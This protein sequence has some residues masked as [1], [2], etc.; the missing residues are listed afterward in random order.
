MARVRC[1]LRVDI[2]YD[3]SLQKI[4]TATIQLPDEDSYKQL[5]G[6]EL[7]TRDWLTILDWSWGDLSFESHLPR[8]VEFEVV[9]R[10]A[11][12]DK[13]VLVRVV[14]DTPRHAMAQAEATRSEYLREF[15]PSAVLYEGEV[16]AIAD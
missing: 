11:E 2:D 14:S 12:D 3:A 8:S 7:S 6:D 1:N 9:G 10:L 5:S 13:S 16:I 15:I 4:E